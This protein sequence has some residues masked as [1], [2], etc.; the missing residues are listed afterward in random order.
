[1]NAGNYEYPFEVLLPDDIPD[2]V[3]G[4]PGGAIIYQMR[5]T[6]ERTGFVNKNIT[7]RKV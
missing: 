1:M 4:L 7:C 6:V 5:A 3:E 2:S